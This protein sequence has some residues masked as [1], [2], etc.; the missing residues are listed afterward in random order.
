MKKI[1]LLLVVAAVGF[2]SCQKEEISTQPPA[3]SYLDGPNLDGP[4]LN[5]PNER[6]YSNY[7]KFPFKY[8]EIDEPVDT[9]SNFRTSDDDF[10]NTAGISAS[11]YDATFVPSREGLTDLKISG[12]NQMSKAGMQL[13]IQEI[14]KHHSGNIVIVDLRA[15]PHGMFNGRPVCLAA[16]RGWGNMGNSIS[17]IINSERDS[18]FSHLN[19]EVRIYSNSEQAYQTWSV[20]SVCTEEEM[21]DSL[22]LIYKRIPA[23]DNAPF[24]CDATLNEFISF[25]RSLPA[26]TWVH[27]HCAKGLGRTSLYMVFYDMMRNPNLSLNDIVYRQYMLGG[28][29]VMN[30]GSTTTT[31]WK[32]EFL[33][34]R[35]LLMPI[36]HDYV[37]EA[38]KAGYSLN[39][40]EWKEQTYE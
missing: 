31:D 38:S 1:C 37:M 29:F 20:R 39:W 8:W 27:F 35:S 17:T 13:L 26:N 30:D 15:E 14:R 21:C 11:Y 22:G 23:H 16:P 36:F 40:T 25:V 9:L 7:G 28:R 32:R 12:G 10:S 34:E 2:A 6:E 24:P 4:N 3:P 19:Q 5:G 18:L 33:Y